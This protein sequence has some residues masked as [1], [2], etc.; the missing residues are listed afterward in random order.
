[1]IRAVVRKELAVTWASPVPYV[2]G[3]LFHAVLG[4]LFVDQLN[5]GDQAVIQPLFPLAGFLLLA[6]VPLVTMRALADEER[7]GSLDV[8]L[9]VPVPTG[10]LVVGKW[11]AALATVIVVVAPAALFAGLL[12]LYGS[13]DTGP[14]LSGYL[15]LVLLAAVLAAV[16]V[17]GSSLTSSLPVA[18][19]AAF[20]VSLLLWF[21]GSA[22]QGV[23]S[24]GLL[25]R[26]SLSERLRAFSGGGIETGDLAVVVALGAGALVLAVAVVDAR[27]L[28]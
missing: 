23:G 9:A 14:I 13:P 11:L 16:G 6:M 17:L 15:G 7:T 1:M 10:R 28:R 3:A 4:I 25:G 8:L 2:T 20:F 24:A 21:A 27:R 12:A 22:G 26:L 19:M 18:A 5:A